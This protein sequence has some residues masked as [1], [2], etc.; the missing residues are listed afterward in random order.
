MVAQAVKR[1]TPADGWLLESFGAS[2]AARRL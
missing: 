1:C 2:F